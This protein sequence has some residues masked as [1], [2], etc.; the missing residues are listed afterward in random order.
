MNKFLTI[1]SKDNSMDTAELAKKTTEMFNLYLEQNKVRQF[2]Q[3]PV[4]M[5]LAIF[6]KTP[7]RW[8]GHLKIAGIEVPY[9][10]HQY[11]EKALS[12]IYNFHVSSEIQDVS[13]Q[14]D[15]KAWVCTVRMKFTLGKGEDKIIR[16][17]VGT[18]RYYPNKATTIG[19]GIK[20]AISKC[21]TVCARRFG[22]GADLEE[23]EN[24]AYQQAT[25]AK[26]APQSPKPEVV[27]KSFDPNF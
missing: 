25:E 9:V 16:E 13:V 10:K 3:V 20:S 2:D 5:K 24:Q 26:A 22:I 1:F 21:W 17:E 27:D 12:F 6:Q 18:H 14:Q 19:D 8:I 11:A 4:W 23:A 15:G 7:E